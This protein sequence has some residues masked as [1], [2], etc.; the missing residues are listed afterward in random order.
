MEPEFVKALAESTAVVVRE[1]IAKSTA[2]LSKRIAALEENS[3]HF[4]GT[5]NRADSYSKGAV[6]N[7]NSSLWCAVKDVDS[8][9]ERPP[10]GGWMLMFR[11]VQ[12]V[13][14]RKSGT[15]E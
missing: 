3:V 13:K 14:E 15:D 11:P 9:S 5:Y 1:A 8:G 2:E 4:R 6:V 12:I 7:H 10:G